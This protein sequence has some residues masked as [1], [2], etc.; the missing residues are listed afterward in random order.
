M[1]WNHESFNF[2]YKRI[3]HQGSPWRR[4]NTILGLVLNS[5]TFDSSDQ[6]ATSKQLK[7]NIIF[8]CRLFGAYPLADVR[9]NPTIFYL[10]CDRLPCVMYVGL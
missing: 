2:H 5:T 3:Q 10:R 1:V 7:F 8:N 6:I 4:Y 9:T